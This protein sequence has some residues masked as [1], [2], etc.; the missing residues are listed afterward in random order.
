MD[1]NEKEKRNKAMT[2]TQRQ[3][4]E[5]NFT[6][7][8]QKAA[9]E[10][11]ERRFGYMDWSPYLI[12]Q[13][14]AALRDRPEKMRKSGYDIEKKPSRET[15][16]EKN[17]RESIISVFERLKDVGLTNQEIEAFTA[18]ADNLTNKED[19]DLAVIQ[20]DKHEEWKK[21]HWKQNDLMLKIDKEELP[22]IKDENKQIA[23][24]RS[25]LLKTIEDDKMPFIRRAAFVYKEP[26]FD[27]KTEELF[28]KNNLVAAA[29]HMALIGTK[30]P[31]YYK[32]EEIKS[33]FELD[34]DA[35]PVTMAYRQTN[36]NGNYGEK[37]EVYYNA[38]QIK[39]IEPYK[40]PEYSGNDRVEKPGPKN[41]PIQ[42][43][44]ENIINWEVALGERGIY[45]PHNKYE[46]SKEDYTR[47]VKIM[48][49]K[50]IAEICY[51]ADERSNEII[52]QR[53][54]EKNLLLSAGTKEENNL[55][56]GGRGL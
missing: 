27:G 45:D 5:V 41:N 37:F 44:Q 16:K 3:S 30:D 32:A 38:G 12:W 54:G 29:L 26:P 34:K 13:E 48:T 17:Q 47:A 43:L 14:I 49:E 19:N 20:W 36:D 7:E 46:F 9:F 40:E 56:G 11:A 28:T 25:M 50:Q 10:K 23:E 15:K 55:K 33:G 53:Q 39:G 22:E 4:K 24:I 21:T 1:N 6:P 35:V 2:E 8:E 42:Q 18:F 31:R 51:Y 52:K